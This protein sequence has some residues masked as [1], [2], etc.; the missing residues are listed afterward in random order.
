MVGDD[1]VGEKN[2]GNDAGSAAVVPGAVVVVV[3]VVVVPAAGAAAGSWWST[4]ENRSRSN[5]RLGHEHGWSWQNAWLL[6]NPAAGVMVRVCLE[7]GW[8]AALTW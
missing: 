1:G 5:R 8:V 7:R 6:H 3:V 4:D 2:D